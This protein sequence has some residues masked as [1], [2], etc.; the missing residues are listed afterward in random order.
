LNLISNGTTTIAYNQVWTS[1]AV[2]RKL[3]CNVFHPWFAIGPNR[4]VKEDQ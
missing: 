3:A 1:A 2:T 4:I